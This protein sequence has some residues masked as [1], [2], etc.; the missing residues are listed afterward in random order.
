MASALF[1]ID[2]LFESINSSTLLLTPNRRLAANLQSAYAEACSKRGLRVWEL[3]DILPFD[4]WVQQC[5]QQLINNDSHL[6][7]NTTRLQ[8]VQE[9]LLW[10][11]IIRDDEKCLLVKPYATAKQAQSAWRTLQLW[12]CEISKDFYFHPDTNRFAHWAGQF[13]AHCQQQNLLNAGAQVQSLL[14]AFEAGELSR[15]NH[16][17]LVGFQHLP[18]LHEQL[19]ESAGEAWEMYRPQQSTAANCRLACDDAGQELTLAAQWA[20]RQLEINPEQR[21]AIIVPD[22]AQQRTAIETALTTVFE[23]QYWLPSTPRYQLPFNISA[24]VSLGNTPLV[25][26]ALGML[27]LLRAEF[28]FQTLYTLLKSPFFSVDE[29]GDFDSGTELELFLRRGGW[30]VFDLTLLIDLISASPQLNSRYAGFIQAL[31]AVRELQAQNSQHRGEPKHWRVVFDTLLQTFSWPAI[32]RR[33]DSVEYQQFNRWKLVLDEFSNLSSG[34]FSICGK[35]GLEEALNLLNRLALSAD[36]QAQTPQTP[37]QVLGMLEGGGLQFDAVWLLGLNDHLWPATANPTPFIPARLQQELNMPHASP[38]RELSFSRE[39]L[40]AYQQSSP[41]VIAS[42]A[43][44]SDDQ[45]L[46]ASTLI[47]DFE[48]I[49]AET[50]GLDIEST[51]HPY[52]QL[53]N[54]APQ[55]EQFKDNSGPNLE[56]DVEQIAGGSA[57]LKDQAACPFRAFAT[58]R[59]TARELTEPD[60]HLNAAQR[61]TLIHR[62]LEQLWNE[63]GNSKNLLACDDTQ[64]K[65]TVSKAVR[66]ALRPLIA[67]RADLFGDCYT[68]TEIDR[69]SL[70]LGRWLEVEKSRAPFEVEAT[71]KALFVDLKGLPLRVRIDR[72]DRLDDGSYMLIDYK[73]GN[74]NTSKWQGERMEEPQLP[75]YSI[76]MAGIDPAESTIQALSFAR[77]SVDQQGFVGISAQESVAPGVYSIEKSRGWNP[78]LR[79]HDIND[80]W[81]QT[82]ESLATDFIKGNADV[83]PVKTNTCQYCR[84]HSLCRIHQIEEQGNGAG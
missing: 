41:V 14:E 69:L 34:D 61:G 8:P 66:L 1:D 83:D 44:H 12:Q 29:T 2:P 77:I 27:E 7:R 81:Q 67:Q 52:Y 37:I 24:G 56:I 62:A 23:P 65:E 43:L 11:R 22:L 50:L 51:P 70:L 42:Y 64:L 80:Q 75:L 3:P 26:S 6:S 55:L 68:E 31:Q 82:L 25:N 54:Q 38:E 53:Y 59:L 33:L 5:W 17:Q 19:I 78:E 72:I 36:F 45:L 18:P 60:Y 4:D 76:C 30:P 73:T 58:H 32:A 35:L 46:R 40:K 47:D 15:L 84:L 9:T 74:C 63:L 16:I 10:E 48:S 13:Q 71:E 20:R 57:I 28:D 79:W 39:L 21:I 49:S